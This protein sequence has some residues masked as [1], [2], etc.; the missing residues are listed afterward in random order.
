[1]G[2]GNARRPAASSPPASE[3]EV[4]F[5]K[6]QGE[7]F[8]YYM[9]TYSIVLGRHSRRSSKDPAAPP[10]EADDGVDVDLGALGGGMNVSRRHARIFYD[11]RRRRF[12]LEVLGK[13]GCF[14]EG[15]HH[16]RGG[17]PV[18]L[19]SQDL[20]QM[21]DAKFYFLLPSRSVFDT[22]IARRASAVPRA[23]PPPPSD[24][25]EDEEEQGEA[26][27]MVK[28]PRNE[29]NGRRADTAGSKAYREADDRILLQL[30]EKDII[31]SAAT[32]LSDLCGPQRWVSMNKL[33]EVMFDKYGNIWHHSRVRKYLTSEDFPESE[34][35]GRPW[36]GFALLLRKN[37]EIFVINI[38]KGG[39][40]STEF[41][42]LVSLQP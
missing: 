32:I 22:G 34:T 18:K 7:C 30:E 41:V 35:D 31:S 38:R 29:N 39:G 17:Q 24:D 42:S 5:A 3:M 15:M 37:P 2:K 36:H 27:G 13:N 12:A 19:D 40:L 11:F 28:R 1:M 23:V 14:V 6:L 26:V 8:E 20:L 16:V 33:H 21:G 25:D 9:Q 4:G 10:P